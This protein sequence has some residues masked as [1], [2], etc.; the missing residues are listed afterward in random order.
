MKKHKTGYKGPAI[1]TMD[2]TIFRDF[3][4]YVEKLRNKLT[5]ISM[6]HNDTVFVSWT[7]KE[8]DSS[9]VTSQL[10][11]FWSQAIGKDVSLN[12]MLV[13]KFASTTVCENLADLKGDAA[14]LMCHSKKTQEKSYHLV[15]KQRKAFATSLLIKKAL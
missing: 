10:S 12:T 13:R 15:D 5:G 9:M 3:K 1:L 8:M 4:I 11:S 14:D 7:G 2:Q 6:Y